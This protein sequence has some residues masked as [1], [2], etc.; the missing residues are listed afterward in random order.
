MAERNVR[1][2]YFN[3]EHDRREDWDWL[4]AW[5]PAVVHFMFQG[6]HTDPASVSVDKIRRIHEVCSSAQI[7]LRCWDVDDR[8]GAAKRAMVANAG[9]EAK[10]QIE[11]WAAVVDRASSSGVPRD[12]MLAGM[13]NET[14]PEMDPAL[15]IYTD[16]ALDLATPLDL[17]LGVGVFSV[18]RPPKIGEASIDMA[19]FSQW[20]D[21]ILA[22][23]GCLVL[24]EYFQREGIR[25]VWIDKEGKERHDYGNLIGRH[26]EWP[27]RVPIII[28]EWGI[29]GLL[30]NRF[31][32][33]KYGHSGWHNFPEW[34]PTR[35][36]DEYVTCVQT[37]DE[38]VIGTC[39][40][41][42]DNADKEG[43]WKSFD[44][45]EA[46]PELLARKHL[47][48]RSD[49]AVPPAGGSFTVN[50]PLV[51]GVTPGQLSVMPELVHPIAD[52]DRRR[53]TQW[54]GEEDKRYF[55][56]GMQ[57]HNGIDFACPMN[58]T[59][60]AVADGIV[61]QSNRMETYG[62][63]IKLVHPWG[64]SVYAHCNTLVVE[65]GDVVRAGQSIAYSGNSGISTGPHLHFGLRIFPY[66]RGWPFD[67]FSDP[68]PYLSGG[69]APVVPAEKVEVSRAMIEAAAAEFDLDWRLLASMTMTESSWNSQKESVL[70]AMGAMQIMPATWA[71][72]GPRV[73]AKNPY[74]PVEN[75]RTGA[76]YLRYLIKYFAGNDRKALWAYVWGMG[77]VGAGKVPPIEVTNYADKVLMGR[78]LLVA[79]GA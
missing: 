52:P 48:V 26:K 76:A 35:Y 55:D 18:G 29:E 51:V 8:S 44:M 79:V 54:F 41:I 70:G 57:G 75:I 15:F 27:M 31:P 73:G 65:D 38:R 53:V 17:R 32:S 23:N 1:G 71:E 21:K 20:Q 33:Q 12:L 66:T 69:V 13:N 14:D 16:H 50:L 24:N 58:S 60:R 7:L 4:E 56:M 67:G 46:Y 2:A 64:E 11:W 30:Y 77:R 68:A 39:G 61:L 5:E 45:L 78:D 22:N 25:G 34:T 42:S 6:Q 9:A 47:C 37:A 49:E 63:V 19:F 3:F 36:A 59:I 74:D 72:W 10:K 62:L 40:F 28:G 43:T